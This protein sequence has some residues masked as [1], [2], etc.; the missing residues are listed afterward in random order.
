MFDH[1]KTER[2]EFFDEKIEFALD[3]FS[4]DEL[5]EAEL[6]NCNE[7]G[8]CILSSKQLSV[9]QEITLRKFMDFSSRSAIVTW[10]TT[11]ERYSAL[12]K[13]CE[14]LFKIGLRF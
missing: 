6:I 8:L 7:T 11:Y 13:S 5:F 3:P 12:D 1:R 4:K 9:G 2:Y 14:I 10:I